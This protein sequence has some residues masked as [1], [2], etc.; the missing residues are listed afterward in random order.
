[1]I[2]GVWSHR[3]DQIG[4]VFCG[5]VE[6]CIEFDNRTGLTK[7]Y[8]RAVDLFSDESGSL[9]LALD[10]VVTPACVVIDAKGVVTK[11]GHALQRDRGGRAGVSLNFGATQ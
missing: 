5:S 1:M 6:D 4:V 7:R 2:F 8:P 3:E 9:A 11:V 10:I